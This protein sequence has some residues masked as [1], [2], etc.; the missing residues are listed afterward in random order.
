MPWKRRI[1]PFL[2]LAVCLLTPFA[3]LAA[4]FGDPRGFLDGARITETPLYLG[5]T[6]YRADGS[7]LSR[8]QVTHV[9]MVDI[10]EPHLTMKALPGERFV[11]ESSG[12][13]FRRSLVSQMQA[14]N[15]ALVAINTAFFDIASTMAPTGLLMKDRIM[16]REPMSGRNTF[17]F[18]Q[19]GLPAV[20]NFG[21]IGTLRYGGASR[22]FSGIN[23]H[24][25]GSSDLAVYQQPWDRSPGT[26]ADF[27][28]GHQI[29]EVLLEKTG[30]TPS[31]DPT[32]PAK[33]RGKVLQI[34]EN[35]PSVSIP[36]NRFVLTASGTA[37]TFLRQMAVHATVEVEWRLTGGPAGLDWN[38]ITQSTPG[39][40]VLVVDGKRQSNTGD[41]W[42][43]LH[44]RSAIGI[45]ADASQLVLLLVEGRQDGR[46]EGM[47]LHSV[48]QYL[49]HMGAFNA[50]EFDGGG[51]SGL[52]AKINGT[53]TRLHTPSDGSERYVPAGLGVQVLR[54]PV[55][56]LFQNIRV[57]S[58]GDEALVSWETAIPAVSYA[59]YGQAKLDRSSAREPVA[60]IRH[61][62]FLSDLTAP[63]SYFAR[64]VAELPDGTT[65]VSQIVPIPMEEQGEIIVDDSEAVFTG[66]PVWSSGAFRTPWGPSYRHTATVT[67]SPT[68]TATY[69]PAIAIS[70]LYDVY[71]WYTQGTNRT[72]D[73]RYQIRHAGGFRNVSVNQTTNGERWLRLASNLRFNAGGASYL[74]IV[75]QSSSGGDVVIADAARWVL[76][77]ADPLEP[78]SVP[79]WWMSH[80]FGEDAPDPTV[81]ADGD[82]STI[83]EEY[84]WGTDPTDPVSRPRYR[85]ERESAEA[86]SLVFSPFHEGRAYRLQSR[87]SLTEGEWKN[88]SG[89]APLRLE[90]GEGLLALPSVTDLRKAF[91]RLEVDE[92]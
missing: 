72:T 22:S 85:L 84:L 57:S 54:E 33:M 7:H 18:T 48:G 10:G 2:F 11:S 17:V 53:N 91:F 5:V 74:R 82:D 62:A 4:D 3:P 87:A 88:V 70:G 12:Q 61:T 52:A 28:S 58:D 39:A 75:N 92:R 90:S 77:S 44:P 76:T 89:P 41:H 45:S 37:R 51:S 67:S 8:P 43:N 86:W 65:H 46:A 36:A 69:T 34:R 24:T 1:P 14:D 59:K 60:N 81:D 30:F 50:L 78:G 9:V 23:R 73:A 21:F 27:T 79:S 16:L 32:T 83:F 56:G 40:H 35:Q 71:A 55:H 38:T 19:D 68:H 13:F 63:G 15:D 20:T 26:S 42:D 31:P 80:F 49:Q 25:F 47:S 6:Y 64:L 66:S 29:T